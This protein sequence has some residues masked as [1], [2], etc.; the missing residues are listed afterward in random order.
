MQAHQNIIADIGEKLGFPLTFDDNNQCLLLLDSDIFMSI[1]AK[2]DIWLLNGMIIPLSPVCGDSVWRQIMVINGELATKN[3]GVLA[4]I[5]TAEALLLIDAIT[6]LT[7]TYHIISQL[8]LFVHQ[9]E[10]LKNRLQE[11]AKL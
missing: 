6:D 10:E 1:E 7:N 11:Y 5:D 3:K 2:D 4:Y 9:Q 8:E